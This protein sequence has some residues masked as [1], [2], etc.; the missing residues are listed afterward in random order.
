MI[1]FFRRFFD[2]CGETNKRKFTNSIFLEVPKALLEA[3]KIPAIAVMLHGAQ[4]NNLT[5]GH[6]ALSFGIML[7]SV[8]EIAMG[9]YLVSITTV[10]EF[11]A[12]M[13]RMHL[14]EKI[15]IQ[16]SVMFHFFSTVMDE[17]A[18]ITVAMK[19]RGIHIGGRNVGKMLEYRLVPLM[20]CCV[21]IGEELSV[22]ALTR[23]PGGEARRIN[24]CKIGFYV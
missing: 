22:A 18:S 11:T 2:F 9:S 6:I 5:L 17:A 7:L 24:I 19:M 15:I 16:L 8:A 13:L 1:R 10:S 14:S 23:G 4:A 12:V 20:T 3:M 21:K